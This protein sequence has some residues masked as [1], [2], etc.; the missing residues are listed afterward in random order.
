[1]HKVRFHNIIEKFKG[2]LQLLDQQPP[3]LRWHR[4]QLR[5]QEGELTPPLQQRHRKQMLQ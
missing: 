5:K 2:Q 4:R 1:M 3:H